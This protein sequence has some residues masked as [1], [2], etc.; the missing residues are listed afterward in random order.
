[1]GIPV[2]VIG[3]Y[4]LLKYLAVSAPS[5]LIEEQEAI[6]SS[7]TENIDKMHYVLDRCLFRRLANGRR[8]VPFRYSNGLFTGKQSLAEHYS[9]AAATL[10]PMNWHFP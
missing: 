10:T 1:V 4:G 3:N 6:Q 8:S 2:T 9:Y 5:L 7:L